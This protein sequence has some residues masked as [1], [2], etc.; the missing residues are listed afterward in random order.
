MRNS[1]VAVG[2]RRVEELVAVVD[3]DADDALFAEV[4][5]LVELRLLDLAL[6][7]DRRPR[8]CP[9]RSSARATIAA[10]FSPGLDPDEV[11]DRAPLARARRERD[12]VDLLDVDLPLVAEE[13]D[14]RVR[15]ATKS[16]VTQSSS[17]ASIPM[18]ALAAA[19]LRP[20]VRRARPLDVAGVGD[21]DDHVLFLDEVLVAGSRRRSRRSR[22]AAC[23]RTSC[24]S[25]RA[26]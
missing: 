16:W 8:T 26:P 13:E 18:L 10:T 25:P 19:L 6:A 20:V 22:C 1:R 9:S 23:R 12:L 7:R 15:A 21:G 3:L 4:L 17:R 2:Q 14:V 5:V 11:H 24:G